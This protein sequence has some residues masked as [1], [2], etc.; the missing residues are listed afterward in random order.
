MNGLIIAGV[1]DA[2]PA[3]VAAVAA[4]L[5]ARAGIHQAALETSEVP[6]TVFFILLSLKGGVHFL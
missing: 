4:T 3:A 1:L 5:A 2:A 6:L